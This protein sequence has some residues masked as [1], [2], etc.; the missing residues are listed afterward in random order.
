MPTWPQ[1]LL[2]PGIDVRTINSAAAHTRELPEP[3]L[4]A[5][6]WHSRVLLPQKKQDAR[7]I[8]ACSLSMTYKKP[9]RHL[10][11]QKTAKMYAYTPEYS[12]QQTIHLAVA[13]DLTKARA[14]Q[15]VCAKNIFM[16]PQAGLE[17]ARS[18]PH[19]ILSQAC[20]PIPPLRRH[21]NIL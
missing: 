19:M 9:N 16:V 8:Q 18:C 20:L 21:R 14:G 4:K 11:S 3:T 7:P 5:P 10:L 1:T 17:P 15:A 12:N 13:R 2:A 6:S